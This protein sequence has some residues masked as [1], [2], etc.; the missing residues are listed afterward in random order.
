MKFNSDPSLFCAGA[1]CDTDVNECADDPCE[2]NGTCTDLIN[3]FTCNCSPGYTGNFY[4]Q[5]NLHKYAHSQLIVQV[6]Q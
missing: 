2:H 5:L 3:A 1:R 6:S 4:V